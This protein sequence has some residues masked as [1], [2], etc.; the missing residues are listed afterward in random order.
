MA[1]PPYFWIS[2]AQEQA[3]ECIRNGASTTG[4][5]A[6]AMRVNHNAAGHMR[7]RLEQLGAIKRGPA[8]ESGTVVTFVAVEGWQPLAER[9]LEPWEAA[10]RAAQALERAWP[11]PK[12]SQPNIKGDDVSEY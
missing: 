1:H 2:K 5:L 9:P 12:I 7:R 10:L 4:E 3:L 8:P 6:A 11:W